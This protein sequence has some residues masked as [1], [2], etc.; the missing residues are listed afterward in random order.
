VPAWFDVKDLP[1]DEPTRYNMDQ[2]YESVNEIAGFINEE[3][4]T[5]YE[6]DSSKIFLTGFS[7][8]SCLAQS[9]YILSQLDPELVHQ[10]N[11]FEF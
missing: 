2:C 3:V 4:A 7:Q 11:L 9:L 1:C 10:K 6:G 5:F 8:G